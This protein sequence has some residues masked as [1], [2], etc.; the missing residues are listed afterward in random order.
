MRRLD[1]DLRL[2]G[3]SPLA[4]GVAMTCCG[5]YESL[6]LVAAGMVNDSFGNMPT[7]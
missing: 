6:R 3:R 7:A 1:R 5:A 2:A 4:W